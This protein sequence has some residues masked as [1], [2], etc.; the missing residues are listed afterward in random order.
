MSVH[1]YNFDW[2]FTKMFKN[3]SRIYIEGADEIF[4]L[5]WSEKTDES[6]VLQ[7]CKKIEEFY[8]QFE[9]ISDFNY[10]NSK[11]QL[12]QSRIFEKNRRSVTFSFR[13]SLIKNQLYV[14]QH[15][16]ILLFVKI[17]TRKKNTE[18]YDS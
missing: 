13:I 8:S 7:E 14:C 4:Q 15:G 10:E 1:T 9:Q 6:Q 18:E 11:S 3:V 12:R 16:C 2:I 17:V 5:F